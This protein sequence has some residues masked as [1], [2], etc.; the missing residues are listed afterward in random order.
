MPTIRRMARL[1]RGMRSAVIRV[2]GDS[3]ADLQRFEVMR[4]TTQKSKSRW[5]TLLRLMPFPAAS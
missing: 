4:L 5:V 3:F 2:N 1:A